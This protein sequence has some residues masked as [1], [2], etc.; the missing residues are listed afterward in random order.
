VVLAEVSG[1]TIKDM[2]E[3]ALMVWPEENGAFPHLAGLTFSVNTAI[4]SS[5]VLNE[6]EEFTGVDGEY[7]V[8]DLNAYRALKPF[9]PD[10]TWNDGEYYA[11]KGEEKDI[12]LSVLSASEGKVLNVAKTSKDALVYL[13]ITSEKATSV[14]VTH[15]IIS[16]T[17]QI[18]KDKT[19]ELLIHEDAT[20]KL[21]GA[22]ATV[23]YREVVRD[24]E[25]LIPDG[26]VKDENQL[27]FNLWLTA[28]FELKP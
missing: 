26:Y 13:Y 6:Y 18:A 4:E 19:F 25:P 17:Y 8:Y 28:S 11:G 20:V 16:R 9:A 24:Y 12:A 2:M 7:R 23:D 5:V 10:M 27:H 22:H 3:M 14:T 15:G 1:Q 21:N